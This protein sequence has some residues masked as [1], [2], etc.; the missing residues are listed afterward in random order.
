MNKEFFN[1]RFFFGP[2]ILVIVFRRWCVS[3]LEGVESGWWWCGRSTRLRDRFGSSRPLL[4]ADWCACALKGC[5]ILKA[6]AGRREGLSLRPS[7]S[8]SALKKRQVSVLQIRKF[9]TFGN[10]SVIFWTGSGTM[11]TCLESGSMEPWNMECK[12]IKNR[13]QF[14]QCIRKQWRK[15][16]RLA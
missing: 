4:S 14:Q 15:T 5:G 2:G 9:W 1:L 7:P 10:E 3:E 6:G 12:K 13:E 8:S 11:T 16:P